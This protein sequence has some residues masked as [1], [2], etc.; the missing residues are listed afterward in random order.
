MSFGGAYAFPG[1]LI[2]EEDYSPNFHHLSCHLA[3]QVP[4]DITKLNKFVLPYF[5]GCIRECFEETGVLLAT[6]IN[7]ATPEYV[8]HDQ[9]PGVLAYQENLNQKNTTLSIICLNEGILPAINELTYL[10]N[11]VTPECAKRRYS[12]RFFIAPMPVGQ[13]ICA[14]RSEILNS[15]WIKPESA[16]DKHF[17][18]AFKMYT[19]TIKSLQAICGYKST[20][21]LINS[22]S[23]ILSK[24]IK[25]FESQCLN[26]S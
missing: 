21:E 8:D 18:G 24:K 19:P 1:G 11:W 10:G 6:K 14:H 26:L 22:K 15:L 25:T 4:Y 12:T 2:C 7:H 20:E 13:N 16:L 17:N 9:M 3:D 5:I 23:T